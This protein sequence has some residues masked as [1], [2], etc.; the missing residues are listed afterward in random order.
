VATAWPGVA[1]EAPA[2]CGSDRAVAKADRY[3]G[4]GAASDGAS[5]E[6]GPEHHQTHAVPRL[7]LASIEDGPRPSGHVHGQ[8]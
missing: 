8:P 7:C 3:G 1:S 4:S 6:G 2:T 5:R